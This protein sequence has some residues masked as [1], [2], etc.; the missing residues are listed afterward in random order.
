[1]DRAVKITIEVPGELA[2][3]RLPPLMELRLQRLL[4]LQDSGHR[5][6]ADER[7]QAEALLEA[8]EVLNLLRLRSERVSCECL[9]PGAPSS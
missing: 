4:D 5:L 2:D 9:P 6:T 3:F 1:M 8:T 7:Q